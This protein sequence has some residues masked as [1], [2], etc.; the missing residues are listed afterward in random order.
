MLAGSLAVISVINKATSPGRR[1]PGI[2]LVLSMFR[3]LI[4]RTH[5]TKILIPI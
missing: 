1:S 3:H 5:E 2:R 4:V